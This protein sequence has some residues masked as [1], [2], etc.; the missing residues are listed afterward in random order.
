MKRSASIF[1][2]V[3]AIISG[4]PGQLIAQRK[5]NIVLIVSDQHQ[6][7]AI[8]SYG[9]E[10]RNVR[11]GSPTPHIDALA[12][13][14][15]RF[16]NAYTASPL[17]APARASLMTGVYPSVHGAL[18]H[19]YLD[20]EPGHNRFPGIPDSLITIGQV[21]RE[22]GYRTAAIG[23]MHVHGEKAGVNDL[24]F[25]RSD[26]RFYTWYPGAHYADRGNGDWN[27]R[28]RELPPYRTMRYHEID[29]VRFG[30]LDPSLTVL[31]NDSYQNKNNIE[32]LVE[33]EHQMM[34]YLVAEESI[35]FIEECAKNDEPF[36]IHVGFEKPHEPY[37]A[38]KKWMELFDPAHMVLPD[39]WNE[40][41]TKG[42]L[43]FV[44]NWLIRADAQE[45]TARNTLASYFA[46]VAFLDEQV[47]KV[48]QACKEAGIY[49]NTVFIYTSDHGDHMYYRSMLQKHCMFESA[50]KIPL[51]M[52]WDK[53]LPAGQSDDKLV[54]W[55]D[56]LPTI[57]AVSEIS[58]PESFQGVSLLEMDAEEERIV[59]SEFYEGNGNYLFFPDTKVLPMR[60][61][62]YKNYKYVYTHGFIEQLYH[63]K[64]DPE[65]QTNLLLSASPQ[66]LE[67]IKYFRLKTFFPWN[68]IN[69]PTLPVQVEHSGETVSLSWKTSGAFSVYTVY[70]STTAS[71]DDF[72]EICNT[73]D[74]SITLTT[75]YPFIRIVADLNLTRMGEGHSDY[76]NHRVATERMPEYMPFSTTLFI[77]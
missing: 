71:F 42:K 33:N 46:G 56:I 9:S 41:H 61:C 14:G 31:E 70:G 27:R 7:N 73:K 32:T 69:Y 1:I 62:R 13:S 29:S 77:H 64:D 24:G 68:I 3:P 11:G 25:D 60:M 40:V 51:I 21:F 34:D 52:V 30:H 38:T 76:H 12:E 16:T 58:T 55:I 74:D 4:I 75:D 8:G 54:S 67:L 57:T 47:G 19:K 59:F 72:H 43:P 45:T 18:H 23:K 35:R 44:M 15:I 28:Y 6:V 39:S 22:N 17:S 36:F 63:L 50:V 2:C 5:P 65:E 26:L 10:N 66:N 37:H 53:H 49:E 48:I 20:T